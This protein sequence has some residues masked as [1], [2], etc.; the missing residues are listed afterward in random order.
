[1]HVKIR[2][3]FADL[4]TSSLED[5]NQRDQLLNFMPECSVYI[6]MLHVNFKCDS[7]ILSFVVP[8]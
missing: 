2:L 7:E 8:N 6:W 4:E 1:M 3:L 5:Q